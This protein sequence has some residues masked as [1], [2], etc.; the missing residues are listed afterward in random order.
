MAF[1]SPRS[2]KAK[3][4]K[5]EGVVAKALAQ[6]TGCEDTRKQPGSGAIEGFSG[7]VLHDPRGW[8]LRIEAKHHAKIANYDRLEKKRLLADVL[9]IDTPGGNFAWV[10]DGFFL[11]LMAR[12]YGRGGQG[13]IAPSIATLTTGK[14]LTTFENW[15][16]D[17]SALVVKPNHCPPRWFMAWDVFCAAWTYAIRAEFDPYREDAA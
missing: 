14:A 2:A 10:E 15:M 3:G 8:A 17:C 12:A 9:I 11:D 16:K 1:K 7:D 4:G 5:F 13:E 6:A